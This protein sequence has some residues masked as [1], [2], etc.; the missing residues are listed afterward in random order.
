MMCLEPFEGL[1]VARQIKRLIDLLVAGTAVVVLAPVMALIAVVIRVVLG[2]PVLFRQVRPGYRGQ[3]FGLVKFRTLRKGTFPDGRPLPI[4]QR[5]TPLGYFL[6]RTSLDE[7]PE[8]FNIVKGDM[9]LVGPR[10]LLTEYLPL[11][12]QRQARRHEVRPGLTGMAQAKGRNF[13]PWRERLELDIWYVDNWSLSLDFKI[14]GWTVTQALTGK[15]VAPADA[16]DY[17]FTGADTQP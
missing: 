14:L 6:R 8:L 12:T 15:G 16:D 1:A 9:S 2:S 10:P 7:L 4:N 5:L 17:Y 11:Y 3:P 13:V